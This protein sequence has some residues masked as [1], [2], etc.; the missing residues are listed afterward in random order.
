MP[1]A[2]SLSLFLRYWSATA[3]Y[4]VRASLY[5]PCWVYRSARRTRAS[6]VFAPSLVSFLY[7][8]MA[9]TTK[10]SE[11][12]ASPTFLKNSVALSLRPRRAY[13]SPM[14]LRTVR[15]FGSCF[16][17]FSYSAIAFCSLP[18]WT[19]FSAALRIFALL[20]VKPRAIVDEQPGRAEVLGPDRGPKLTHEQRGLRKL[21]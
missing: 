19:Y 3:M 14:V 5:S 16:E 8:A 7:I 15:S 10:P 2:F 18:C 1:A 11:A 9:L 21:G 6:G 20:N 4:C 13:R 17:I 12:Y